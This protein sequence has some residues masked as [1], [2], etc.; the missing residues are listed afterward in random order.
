MYTCV[1]KRN[2]SQKGN[3]RGSYTKPDRQNGMALRG[4]PPCAT[5]SIAGMDKAVPSLRVTFE[6]LDNQNDIDAMW[7]LITTPKNIDEWLDGDDE[8]IPTQYAQEL[9]Q[10]VNQAPK[11]WYKHVARLDESFTHLVNVVGVNGC[12]KVQL[13]NLKND[14]FNGMTGI[15]EGVFA[16]N[17]KL[18]VRVALSHSTILV[19]PK[20]LSKV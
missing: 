9:A 1:T 19:R 16:K 10:Y 15:M 5:F 6:R 7:D 13:I 3:K 14:R 12:E 11:G 17:G 4:I 2:H 18:R 20:N 8:W